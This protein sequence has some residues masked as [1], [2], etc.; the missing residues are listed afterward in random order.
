VQPTQ[1]VPF[2]RVSLHLLLAGLDCCLLRELPLSFSSRAPVSYVLGFAQQ[3]L[4]FDGKYHR[5]QVNLTNKEK[6]TLQARHGYFAPTA[7]SDSDPARSEAAAKKEIEQA[8]FSH[9]EIR[10]FPIDCETLPSTTAN[11][12]HLALVVHITTKG[13]RFVRVGDHSNDNMT[14]V[15]ALFDE[16]GKMVAGLQK[17]VLMQLTDATIERFN[18]SGLYVKFESDLQPGTYLV[19]IA[20]RDSEGGQM[21]TMGRAL[22]LPK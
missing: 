17:I 20:A 10:D 5:L 14:V 22:V 13:L 1:T 15:T 4:K 3:N 6:W 2:H 11:G 8:V 19:R 7:L 9:Q 16:N 21:A 12:V 18:A